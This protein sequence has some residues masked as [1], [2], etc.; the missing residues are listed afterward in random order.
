[1]AGMVA[2]R[3]VKW[4][5]S[6][7]PELAAIASLQQ[8]REELLA[9][10]RGQ[11]SSSDGAVM[12]LTQPVNRVV[13]A[14]DIMANYDATDIARHVAEILQTDPKPLIVKVGEPSKRYTVLSP[15][16]D[17]DQAESIRSGIEDNLL[18]GISLEPSS[19]R[20]YPSGSLASHVV[21][22]VNGAGV[23][24]A[25]VESYY[26]EELA[27]KP[28]RLIRD[29]DP[30]G[31]S[32]VVGRYDPLPPQA[33]VNITLTIDRPIQHI[34]EQELEQ[35]LARFGSTDGTIIVMNPKSGDVLAIAN[36][37]TFNPA[38]LEEYSSIGRD[39][40]NPT[41]SLVFDPGSTFKI[42]TMA[43]GLQSGSIGPYSTHNLPGA[44]EYYGLEFKNW[45]ERTYPNQTMVSVLANSSNTGAIYVA[46]RLGPDEFYAYVRAFGFG[47]PT[48][49]DLAGEVRG[50]LKA[51]GHIG[52]YPSD[53]A[54]NA[55][56]QSISVTPIQLAA[57][58]GAVANGGVLMRPRVVSR[59]KY[60]SGETIER[61]PEPVRE[62]LSSKSANTLIGMMYTAEHA[63][64]TNLAL[65]EK[66]STVGKTG[67]AEIPDR[68]GILPEQ[69]IASYV[70]FG[71]RDDPQVLVLVKI[72][73]PQTGTWGSQVASPVFRAVVDRVFPHLR[74]NPEQ[75]N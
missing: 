58:F 71:P 4:Q 22:F 70:G 62:V 72:D 51:R 67:T 2:Q 32:I 42:I 37:P 65:S 55:F 56:G 30:A 54:A 18:Q 47:S 1:M 17:P 75:S 8:R 24:Q 14:P 5:I 64:P 15:A 29:Q 44:Y 53:L 27:G 13:A 35:A 36:R 12:A 45:D 50:F 59:W 66:F 19:R 52:W 7:S 6:E 60:P 41:V 61:E 49:I 10:R 3:L 16:T 9:A 11:I 48:G 74:I 68:G 31:R 73:R 28:G 26:D 25:G 63:L 34:A 38:K 39:F 46:D 43:A 23:G 40:L 69:T 33:G 21:G 57:A 20:V